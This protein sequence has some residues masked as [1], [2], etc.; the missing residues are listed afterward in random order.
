[1]PPR[2][3]LGKVGLDGH[4][5]GLHVVARALRDAGYEVILAPIRQTAAQIALAA[6]QEDVAAIGLSSL[7]GAHATHFRRV[8]AALR[9]AGRPDILLFGGG[10]I[11]PED[12]EALS[13]EGFVAVFGPGTR[14]DE[15]VSSLDR[16]L[17]P[18]AARAG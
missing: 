12:A 15:I 3:L 2:I 7:S 17:R 10:I 6:V 4:D 9:E 13:R 18:E 5:R 14:L 1:M 8:A 11:P 16:R